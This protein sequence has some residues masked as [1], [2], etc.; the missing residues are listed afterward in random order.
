V[1][2]RYVIRRTDGTAAEYLTASGKWSAQRSSGRTMTRRDARK[3][4]DDW[5]RYF[6]I[7]RLFFRAHMEIVESEAA[8]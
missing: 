2:V 6:Q 7:R 8:P 4:A 1:T 3:H 5:N